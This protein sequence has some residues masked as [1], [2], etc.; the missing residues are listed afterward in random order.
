[1]KLGQWY[2]AHH[3]FDYDVHIKVEKYTEDI[4]PWD[5]CYTIELVTIDYPNGDPCKSEPKIITISDRLL[6]AHNN[7]L[8]ECIDYLKCAELDLLKTGTILG[9]DDWLTIISYALED[10]QSNKSDANYLDYR[11]VK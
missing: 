9:I 5:Y 8:I 4:Y 11:T 10:F 6:N 3:P 7:S 1:M 2:K